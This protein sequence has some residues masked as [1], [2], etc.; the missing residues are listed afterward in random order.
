MENPDED[1]GYA[2]GWSDGYDHAKSEF[3]AMTETPKA[4]PTFAEIKEGLRRTASGVL[5][6]MPLDGGPPREQPYNPPPD[7]AQPE[8]DLAGYHAQRQGLPNPPQPVPTGPQGSFGMAID[9]LVAGKM[10]ARRGSNVW[11]RLHV[12]NPDDPFDRAA[13]IL[14][15]HSGATQW[16]WT[17][18]LDDLIARDWS[19]VE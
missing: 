16:G 1:A 3:K 19:V 7:W 2:L 9:A 15:A 18:M 14:T 12:P 11:L 8:V 13:I 5:Y 4:E 10:V 17:P 6:G